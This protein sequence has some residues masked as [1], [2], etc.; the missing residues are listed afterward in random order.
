M[1][2]YENRLQKY[3]FC[4][5]YKS[6][7]DVNA[8]V[9]NGCLCNMGLRFIQYNILILLCYPGQ[10]RT[11]PE[12]NLPYF[13]Q[14]SPEVRF[15]YTSSCCDPSVTVYATDMNANTAQRTI[16]EEG[17]LSRYDRI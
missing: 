2:Y 15:R 3:C 16:G 1:R 17:M 6:K 12:S 11:S 9:F 5:N 8:H 7:I 13:Q 10:I 14:G 4:D